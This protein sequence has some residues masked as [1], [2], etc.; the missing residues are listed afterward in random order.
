MSENV[1]KRTASVVA[2]QLGLSYT[3]TVVYAT[4]TDWSLKSLFLK[5]AMQLNFSLHSAIVWSLPRQKTNTCSMSTFIRQKQQIIRAGKTDIYKKR[6]T[7][8]ISD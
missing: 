4:Q 8:I 3:Y 7:L 2:R 6:G 1:R 5:R